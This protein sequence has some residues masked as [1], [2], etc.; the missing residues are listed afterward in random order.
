[1]FARTNVIYG[2]EMQLPTI[3][4]NAL[5]ERPPE[6]IIDKVSCSALFLYD[7]IDI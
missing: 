4:I 3:I 7:K 5:Q 6:E 1:M 2:N